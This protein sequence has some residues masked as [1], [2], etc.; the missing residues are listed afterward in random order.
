MSFYRNVLFPRLNDLAVRHFESERRELLQKARGDVLEIGFGTGI[1]LGSYPGTIRSLTG[2]E[3]NP[4]MLRRAETTVAA[5]NR[6]PVRLAA[7]KAES[8][9]FS[10]E[11]FD[12]VVSVLTLCSVDDVERA[13]AEVRRVLRG[14]GSLLFI[15]HGMQPAPG[16]TRSLQRGLNPLWKKLACGCNLTRLPADEISKSGLALEELKV[17]GRDGFPNILSP[18]HFGIARKT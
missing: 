18:I 17:L 15:E 14:G 16:V 1:S 6:F 11:V 9:P 12:T 10:D 4:G 2:L 8:M 7:G 5:A 13:L 3:P